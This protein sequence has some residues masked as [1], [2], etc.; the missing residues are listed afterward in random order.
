MA[1]LLYVPILSKKKETMCWISKSRWEGKKETST[2]S[3]QIF[4]S[5]EREETRDNLSSEKERGVSDAV[6]HLII[7][8]FH[9]SNFI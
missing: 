4:F 7:E 5:N 8:Y 3:F 1:G 6:I 2:F 9:V